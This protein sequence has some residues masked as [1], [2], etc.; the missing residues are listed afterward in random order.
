MLRKNMLQPGLMLIITTISQ[1]DIFFLNGD[2]NL[3]LNDIK[4]C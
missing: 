2:K 3:W 1:P 4:L